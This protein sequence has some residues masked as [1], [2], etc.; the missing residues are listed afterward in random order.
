MNECVHWRKIWTKRERE[1]EWGKK[2]ENVT[3]KIVCCVNF[4]SFFL[5]FFF[6]CFR[7]CLLLLCVYTVAIQFRFSVSSFVVVDVSFFFLFFLLLLP[8]LLSVLCLEWN[9]LDVARTNSVARFLSIIIIISRKK[10]RIFFYLF[11]FDRKQHVLG[12]NE[13]EYNFRRRRRRRRLCSKALGTNNEN[14]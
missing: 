9:F 2:N 4:L 12:L 7:F 13:L 1:S 3:I 8:S 5:S 14:N 6:V 10:K 11:F